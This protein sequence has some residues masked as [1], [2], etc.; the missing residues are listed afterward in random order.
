MVLGDVEHAVNS[1]DETVRCLTC[2]TGPGVRVRRAQATTLRDAMN[3]LKRAS[4]G[5]G[6]RSG[7]TLL[8]GS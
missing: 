5:I 7:I 6:T 2:R 3:A 4:P 1:D 8:G